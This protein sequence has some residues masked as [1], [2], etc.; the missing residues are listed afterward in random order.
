LRALPVFTDIVFAVTNPVVEIE[1]AANDPVVVIL[2]EVLIAVVPL[3]VP[4]VIE[5][6]VVT[7]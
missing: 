2:P 7:P 6:P 3:I 5:S 4:D 1:P